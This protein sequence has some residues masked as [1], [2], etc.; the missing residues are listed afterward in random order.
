MNLVVASSKPSFHP[1][2]KP[3]LVIISLA[4]SLPALAIEWL[5]EP[6][7]Q[8][9]T[10]IAWA[11]DTFKDYVLEH[12]PDMKTWTEETPFSATGL[13]FT[14][15]FD[16][17]GNDRMFYRLKEADITPPTVTSTY[18]ADGDIA[19]RPTHPIVVEFFDETEIDPSTFELTI[20]APGFTETV[21]IA[22]T[23]N[24]IVKD[25]EYYCAFIYEA[26]SAFAAM[27]ESVSVSAKVSDIHSNEQTV[28]WSFQTQLETILKANTFVFGGVEAQGLGQALDPD[29]IYMKERLG[30][31]IVNG[32]ETWEIALVDPTGVL[33]VGDDLIDAQAIHGRLSV[34]DQIMN[35]TTKFLHQV[36][37]KRITA[38]GQLLTDTDPDTGDPIY[39]FIIQA[40]DIAI[41]EC[42]DQ[43]S[44]S[45]D[46]AAIRFDVI[47]FED[48]D[49][50][51]NPLY[52]WELDVTSEED[53]ENDPGDALLQ[54]PDVAR[55]GALVEKFGNKI[56]KTVEKGFN[57]VKD[58]VESG[59]RRGANAVKNVV[60]RLTTINRT[61]SSPNFTARL[62]FNPTFT[63][64][65]SGA[66]GGNG[67]VQGSIEAG[68]TES[69]FQV[70]SNVTGHLEKRLLGGGRARARVTVTPAIEA[71]CKPFIQANITG[72]YEKSLEIIPKKVIGNYHIPVGPISIPVTASAGVDFELSGEASLTGRAETGFRYDKSMSFTYSFDNQRSNRHE[73]KWSI[74]GGGFQKL[75]LDLNASGEVTVKA[76]LKP[77]L[78]AG[79][80]YQTSVSFA[81]LAAGLRAELEP[82]A[83]I[84]GT[85]EGSYHSDR[86][87]EATLTGKLCAE[88]GLDFGIGYFYNLFGFEGSD[89]P[90]TLPIV[91][92]I[93]LFCVELG[94]DLAI[95]VLV[96]RECKTKLGA[97]IVCA[98]D[99][100]SAIASNLRQ[101]SYQWIKRSGSVFDPDTPIPGQNSRELRLG[102]ATDYHRD[103]V[104]PYYKVEISDGVTTREQSFKLTVE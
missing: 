32:R 8:D 98:P 103:D 72:T 92:A 15:N 99:T 82:Y 79:F 35:T 80:G 25:F 9:E 37:T 31:A 45:I 101:L 40:A 97:D 83:Q 53:L 104:W 16:L 10:R 2:M 13:T 100:P 88:A 77:Y 73:T 68:L 30:Q 90:L 56:G 54:N 12:S 91:P 65:A 67:T 49:N 84:K 93:E 85:V 95:A 62:D 14:K 52:F 42:F 33:I 69:Y 1:P 48:E 78:N 19:I 7:S 89:T 75:P 87:V 64:S 46:A 86:I 94:Y 71:Q 66:I 81:N 60:R 63:V 18:P 58:A 29:D 47:E 76:A 50:E 61:F 74:T 57:K 26:D 27:D 34:G 6:L 4:L 43:L 41:D 36:F 5:I 11:T 20:T 23:G 24:V 38:I 51:G 21:T 3:I 39:G 102:T 17:D 55:L 96:G 44:C 70:S 59:V 22:N 28:T